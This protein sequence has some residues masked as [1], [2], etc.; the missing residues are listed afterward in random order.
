M[1][2]AKK[3]LPTRHEEID[4]AS[5]LKSV[6]LFT[7]VAHAPGALEK[8]AE[9]MKMRR[10]APG[11]TIIRE[12]EKGSEMF[13]LVEGSASVYKSTAENDE[14]KVTILNASHHPF[15]GE[16]ALLES[17]ARSATIKAD[18]ECACLVL[19]REPFLAF[20]HNYPQL[21]FPIL[22]RIAKT[23]MNRF[24]KA[25]TDLVLLYHALVSEIRGH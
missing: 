21:A 3:T 1:M 23:V 18:S 20:G 14:Y 15:F 8:I 17:D 7:D 25:N 11:D 2:L 12:G 4:F 19:E 16:G 5:H 13:L 22:L 9:L 24:Q 10:Y 6:S